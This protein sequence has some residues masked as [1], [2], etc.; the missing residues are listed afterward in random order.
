MTDAASR[1]LTLA[2]EALGMDVAWLS[3]YTG[4]S[5]VLRALEG[6][7]EPFDIQ[8]GT[9]FAWEGSY[10]ARVIDGRLPATIPDARAN[11]RTAQLPITER[12][13]IGAY[14]GAPVRTPD[15]QLFGM[16]CCVGRGPHPALDESDARLLGALASAL[17]EDL[18][19]EMRDDSDA[20][21][22]R[23][24][25]ESAVAGTGLVSVFQPIVS[26]A[27]MRVAG[28]EALAR[29][30]EPPVRPD[31]WFA[32]AEEFEL[33]TALELTSIR[34]ALARL[35]EL[36]EGVYL[37]I[38]ASPETACSPKLAE[39]ITA[40]DASRVVV[41]ITEHSS[42]RDYDVLLRHL[43]GL[44]AMGARLAVD[45]AG[46]GYASFRH[47]LALRPEIVKLDHAL[48]TGLDHDPVRE[49]LVAALL[50]FADRMGATTI[51]EGIETAGEL[52][53]LI[54]LGVPCGQGYHL[55]RP[56]PLP[57]PSITARPTTRRLAEPIAAPSAADDPPEDELTRRLMPLLGEMVALTGLDASYVNIRRENGDHLEHRYVF[58]PTAMGIPLGAAVPWCDTLCSRCFDAGILW[59][60]DV[61]TDLPGG[62]MPY[63]IDARTYISVPV[64][65]PAEG[66]MIGT[67]CAIGRERRFLSDA[68]IARVQGLGR[69]IADHL[70]GEWLR[71]L[72]E[73]R[74]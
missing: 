38:N 40:V 25:V 24:E 4:D 61:Q 26:L 33:R 55:G 1:Y 70:I 39:A 12:L 50:T 42:V 64:M 48:V 46:S 20:G 73:A 15:G 52:D 29:F 6:A 63:G 51:A 66:R 65:S 47:I 10:C 31:A 35:A 17:G 36:P 34:L 22:R 45:D 30:T 74:N 49:T 54:R 44:R 32:Y 62:A 9:A 3:E 72:R 69:T 53:V 18:A 56:G 7:T 8:E 60:A 19:D 41:E 16:L 67:L 23:R 27:N 43:D 57:I 58:D 11:P 71:Q 68:V 2:R 14:A 37:S 13:G 28:V 21:A 5:Q 59:T